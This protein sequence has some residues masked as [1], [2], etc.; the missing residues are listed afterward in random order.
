MYKVFEYS[1]LGGAEILQIRYPHIDAQIDDVI[2][3]IT[4]V[5]KTKAS[6]EKTKK[7][8]MLYSPKVL[9]AKF[10]TLFKQHGFQ[11]LRDQFTIDIPGH[12]YKIKGNFKQVDFAKDQVLCEVQFGKYFSMFYDLAK[13]QYFF[14]E[15]NCEVGVEIV[16]THNLK[17]QM[18][19]GVAYGEALIFDI[20]R[21]RRHFPAV[22]VK[23]ILIDV[24]PRPDHVVIA[25][26]GLEAS[27]AMQ[28]ENLDEL[29]PS[30]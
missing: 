19:S 21:L 22:P 15:S 23:V 2:Y 17:R 26:E 24:E 4:D 11:E 14:N 28:T 25:E 9:N 3:S 8:M 27:L 5:S 7:G 20:T 1:H 6:A 12:T 30:E 18:S 13:F 29:E 16:P 10:R